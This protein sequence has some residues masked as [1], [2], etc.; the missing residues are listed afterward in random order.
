M[1]DIRTTHFKKVKTNN[2]SVP[3]L[4]KMLRKLIRDF[5]NDVGANSFEE[6]YIDTCVHK[7]IIN[8]PTLTLKDVQIAFD[9]FVTRNLHFQ[10]QKSYEI[11]TNKFNLS[12]ATR[13]LSHYKDFVKEPEKIV[14]KDEGY[15]HTQESADLESFKTIIKIYH[16][17]LKTN[18]IT[19]FN[20]PFI[21]D[22]L[23]ERGIIKMNQQFWANYYYEA[24]QIKVD[25][26]DSNP[27]ADIISQLSNEKKED[28]E[29][30][31]IEGEDSNITKK[32]KVLV[33][34]ALFKHWF[35]KEIDVEEH[36]KKNLFKN[37]GYE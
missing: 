8:Y 35:E 3:T 28:K 4:K 34:K 36:L 31:W 10:N 33:L 18:E 5:A 26:E 16:E 23:S 6:D 19:F 13:V 12:F 2:V 1:E 20:P 25:K 27:I 24:S 9:K 7:I 37:K 15:N 29:A 21:Y 22:L 14:L 11:F 17:F 32:A 30:S